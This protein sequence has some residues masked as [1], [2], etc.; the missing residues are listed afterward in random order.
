VFHRFVLG[1]LGWDFGANLAQRCCRHNSLLT[2]S[3]AIRTLSASV[4]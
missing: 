3:G 4:R 2:A 1:C